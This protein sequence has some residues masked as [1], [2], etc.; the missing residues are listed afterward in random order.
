MFEKILICLTIL[1]LLYY[2][3][4]I[5]MDMFITPAGVASESNIPDEDEIDIS[6]EVNSFHS[7][8]VRRSQTAVPGKITKTDD[9]RNPALRRPLMTNGIPVD[10][11][12]NKARN[13][14]TTKDTALAG[15]GEIVVKCESAA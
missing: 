4:L 1:L 7:I 6:E 9:N 10:I 15:L 14:S 13:I 2:V 11:L 12:V 5:C 8:E 3:A